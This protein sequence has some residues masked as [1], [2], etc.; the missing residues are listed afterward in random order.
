MN[1]FSPCTHPLGSRPLEGLIHEWKVNSF[2]N[3]RTKQ[4]IPS[5]VVSSSKSTSRSQTS[6]LQRKH[7]PLEKHKALEQPYVFWKAMFR[8]LLRLIATVARQPRPPS[9]PFRRYTGRAAS[10]SVSP[11]KL[12]RCFFVRKKSGCK[13]ISLWL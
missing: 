9:P 11:V 3:H 6:K 2:K 4:Q 5:N 12:F 13:F 10:Y 1:L 7:M 8:G